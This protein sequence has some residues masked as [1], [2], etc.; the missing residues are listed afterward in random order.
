MVGNSFT[1]FHYYLAVPFCLCT[2]VFPFIC[3]ASNL[4]FVDSDV[5]FCATAGRTGKEGRKPRG[6]VCE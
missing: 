1:F 5:G 3:L 6:S 2:F 4:V